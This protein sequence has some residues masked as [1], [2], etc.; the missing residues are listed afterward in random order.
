MH[1]AIDTGSPQP[2]SHNGLFMREADGVITFGDWLPDLPEYNNSGLL[3][4]KNVLPL[5]GTYKPFKP[6]VSTGNALSAR[7][8][9]AIEVYLPASNTRYVYAGL[10]QSIQRQL[11]AAG[12]WTDVKSTAYS[13][14]TTSWEF[15]VYDELVIATNYFNDP[16]C[17]AAGTGSFAAL[18]TT[19]SAPKARRV[20]KIG[21]FIFLGDT[22]DG[23]NGAVPH[24][25]Q[26]GAVDDPRNW[27]TP[28]TLAAVTVQS[29]QQFLDSQWGPVMAIVGGDQFGIIMQRGGLTRV[30]YVG[31]AVV[32]QFDK[33]AG[34]N[35]VYLPHSVVEDN[36]RWFFISE[37]GICVTNG[38]STE[39]VGYGKVDRTFLANAFA[40]FEERIYGAIDTQQKLIHWCYPSGALGVMDR[41]LILNHT[42]KRFTYAAETCD[43]L[44]TAAGDAS[45]KS[46]IRA[47]ASDLKIAKFTG[48][49]TAAAVLTSGEQEFNPGLYTRAQG[50]KPHV[51]GTSPTVT[52][53]LGTRDSQGS[54]VTYTS[55]TTP[56]ARTGF[57]D[58][59]S[60][61][62]Y[63][64]ART[65]ITGNFEKA[66]G[67]EYQ[68]VPSGAT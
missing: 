32:F 26:W 55:E 5:D 42:E 59:D 49:P 46:Y 3:D 22:N 25:V 35:G 50:V 51:V 61:A 7:P 68:Q 21:Q 17:Q 58:F 47:F 62:R 41:L 2:H 44:V 31:G 30:T 33:I 38:T 14:S 52:V 29:G 45:S 4:A 57:S 1:G 11:T 16:E 40:S 66:M 27:P 12:T 10:T 65:T 34:A 18:A 28:G 39:P 20:G 43:C 63:H 23:T 37:S 56:T 54:A 60:E 13:A 67:L 36:G 6:L 19:G 8:I 64:R 24:R 15:E 9:G 48:T 53:A